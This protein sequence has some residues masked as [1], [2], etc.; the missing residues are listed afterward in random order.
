[1]DESYAEILSDLDAMRSSTGLRAYAQKNP[2]DEYQQEALEMFENLVKDVKSD[3]CQLLLK[4]SPYSYLRNQ[5][6]DLDEKESTNTTVDFRVKK[7]IRNPKPN[8]VPY[9]IGGYLPSIGV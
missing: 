8:G 5:E 4:L 1:M 7:F 6:D 9:K 2:F 3:F